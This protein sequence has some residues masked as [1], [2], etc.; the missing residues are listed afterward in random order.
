MALS[1][2]VSA[3]AGSAGAAL[4]SIEPPLMA[5][6]AGADPSRAPGTVGRVSP[7][8]GVCANATLLTKTSNQ[9]VTFMASTEQI[10]LH[11]GR[12]LTPIADSE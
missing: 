12:A 7:T 8:P 5:P 10:S 4:L 1:D 11:V 3:F 9:N 6:S 2:C